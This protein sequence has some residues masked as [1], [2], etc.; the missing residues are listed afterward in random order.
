MDWLYY[1]SKK[2]KKRHL[3]NFY[4]KD[5][6]KVALHRLLY[7]NFKGEISMKDYIKYSCPN[8]GKCCNINHMVKFE[9]NS[10]ELEDE[11][12][13]EDIESEDSEEEDFKI[14]IY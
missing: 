5:K 7:A 14:V 8:K 4:F 3:Y 13:L 6:K 10:N 1:K 12:D 2:Q 9:Y 11:D